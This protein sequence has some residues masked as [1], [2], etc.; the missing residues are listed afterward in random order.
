MF[1]LSLTG[2][3]HTTLVELSHVK[4]ESILAYCSMMDSRTGS[5]FLRAKF[6][7]HQRE[8]IK[9]NIFTIVVLVPL[10]G[11]ML[12]IITKLAVYTTYIPLIYC[13]LGD[14]MIPTTY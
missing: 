4:S 2:I 8:L 11:G 12:Y 6:I 13:Q 14:Y 1:C 5:G 7:R 10:I 3:G 9:R